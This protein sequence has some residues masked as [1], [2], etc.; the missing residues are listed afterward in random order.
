MR[1]LGEATDHFAQTEI[2]QMDVALGEASKP[3]GK[4]S[5]DLSAM[6]SM[7][8]QVGAGGFIREAEYLQAQSEAQ[9][10]STVNDQSSI[11]RPDLSSAPPGFAAGPAPGV[12]GMSTTF[13][14]L[15][16]AAQIYVCDS[17]PNQPSIN[18]VELMLTS[19]AHIGISR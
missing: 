16:T 6:S 8:N 11:S 19:T 2:D 18:M 15:K 12:P 4:K 17:L 14:P 13:D 7:L 5:A 10:R 1:R 9:A 3:S